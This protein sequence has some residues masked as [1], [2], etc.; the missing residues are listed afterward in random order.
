LSRSQAEL[1]SDRIARHEW[2]NRFKIM[3]VKRLGPSLVPSE[4]V[5]PLARLGD[6]M[7]EIGSKVDQPVVKEGLVIRDGVNGEPEV[8]ILGFIPL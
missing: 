8:V 2:R 6:V 7:T 1:L 5:I 3:L 4:V